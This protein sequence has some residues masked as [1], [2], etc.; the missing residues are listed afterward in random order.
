MT[1]YR[2]LLH[3]RFAIWNF[4]YRSHVLTTNCPF[5]DVNHVG[6]YGSPSAVIKIFQND[7]TRMRII[8]GPRAMRR[9]M[10]GPERRDKSPEC[11]PLSGLTPNTRVVLSAGK[12]LSP[13][14]LFLWERRGRCRIVSAEIKSW[15]VAGELQ[16]KGAGTSY[17]ATRRGSCTASLKLVLQIYRLV[18]A[19]PAK[20]RKRFAW[21]PRRG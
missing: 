10:K 16:I 1:G 9:K 4:K 7:F 8:A 18:P 20:P 6:S 17:M 19:T 21:F 2:L 15:Y 14:P 13:F 5:R 11:V 3:S 12:A